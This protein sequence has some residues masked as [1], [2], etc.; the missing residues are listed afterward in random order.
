MPLP[1]LPRLAVPPAD[2]PMELPAIKLSDVSVPRM[3]TPSPTFSAMT[4]MPL[5][6]VP[7]I[8]LSEAPC[9][10]LRIPA[11]PLPRPEA[12]VEFVPIQLPWITVCWALSRTIPSFVFPVITFPAPAAVPPIVLPVRGD[13]DSVFV[14][15]NLASSDR[16]VVASDGDS[17][18]AESF[19]FYVLNAV[20]AAGDVQAVS[21]RRT[22][23]QRDRTGD[24]DLVRLRAGSD[25]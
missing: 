19:Y 12:P 20:L 3:S 18:P 1:W 8:V 13:V 17:C 25:D 4:L 16:T 15:G 10:Q 24:G 23:V 14:V 11:A 9:P 22:A 2:V 21:A 6:E 7:P 5:D